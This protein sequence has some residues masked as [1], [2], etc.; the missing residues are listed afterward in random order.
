M[1]KLKNE[2]REWL[3]WGKGMES[4]VTNYFKDLLS[5]Q[6]CNP[7]PILRCVH[8]KVTDE[9]NGKLTKIFVASEVKAAVFAMNPN[10]SSGSDEVG[11]CFF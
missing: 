8:R 5:S 11:V 4:L 2:A 6:G 9:Q 3:E 7:D 10:K 1:M